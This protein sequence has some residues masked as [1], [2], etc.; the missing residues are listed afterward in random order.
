MK[1][2]MRQHRQA[3][4]QAVGKLMAH[5][6]STLL[7][8]LVIGVALALPAGGYVLLAN[9]QQL[10]QRLAPQPQLSVFLG[11][12]VT[13]M[14][15]A[16]LGARLAADA[17]VLEA[18][19]VPRDQ[20]LKELAAAEG[21]ADVVAALSQN[22]L[23]DAYVVLARSWERQGLE[24]FAAELRSAPGV[25]RVQLDSAWAQRLGAL[26]RAARIALGLLASLLGVGLVAI[27]FNTIRLHIV[28]QSAEIELLRLIGATDAFI[29]RP[30][31]Y[32]GLL[33]A[34]AGAMMALAMLATGI[35]ALNIGVREVAQSYG[36][37]FQLAFLGGAE[38]L[39]LLA[40]SGSLG[41][42]GDDYL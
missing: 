41:W 24:A 40:I 34:I 7:G 33:Q 4:G 37:A 22:P 20:A 25:S 1:T 27:L 31:L 17:R 26:A 10:T 18:R 3:L 32:Y 38:S 13:Q 11:R 5:R 9:L 15:T 30:F 35:A 21:L 2:W 14:Q 19:F 39:V 42:L 36:S 29:A 6:T 28:T 8:A 12:E 16:A 23:P